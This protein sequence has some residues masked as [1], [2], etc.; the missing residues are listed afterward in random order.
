MSLNPGGVILTVLGVV[1]ILIGVKGT[2]SKVFLALT[3]T[4]SG[5]TPATA[6]PAMPGAAPGASALNPQPVPSGP[7]QPGPRG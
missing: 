7:P 1:L 4:P 5:T 6:A 2:Q 3:G